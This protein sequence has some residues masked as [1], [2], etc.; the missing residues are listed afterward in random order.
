MEIPVHINLPVNI[1]HLKFININGIL[2]G[3]PSSHKT[4]LDL[5]SNDIYVNNKISRGVGG[6]GY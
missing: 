5:L 3:N 6:G 2:N 1:K 4:C